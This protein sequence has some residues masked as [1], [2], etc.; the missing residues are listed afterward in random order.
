MKRTY[1]VAATR[2]QLAE[3]IDKVVSGEDVEI[4]RRGKRVA[5][6]VSPARY[7]RLSGDRPGFG[8]LYAAFM[9]KHDPRTFGVDED[10]AAN[11]RDRSMGRP[12]K[13]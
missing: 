13:L 5:I 10:F 11:L 6:L 7:A 8:E 3:I 4:M 12:V 1:S 9:Q 2:A